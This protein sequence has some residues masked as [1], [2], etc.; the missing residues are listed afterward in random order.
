M[1]KKDVVYLGL[2]GGVDSAIAAVLLLEQGYDV[3]GVFLKI[4][5]D[6]LDEKNICPWVEERRDAINV[7]AKLGI[8]IE[9][10]DFE[11]AYK[12]DVFSYFVSEYSAG[13]T[14][15]PDI[16]CNQVI[17]FG[18]FLDYALKQGADYIATG[19]HVRRDPVSG[20]SNTVKLLA[21]IDQKKDQS[22]FLS[23]LNQFQLSHTL[24]P[25]GHMTKDQVREKA[26][27]LGLHNADKPSTKG[28]CFIGDVNLKEFLERYTI[29]QP[30]NIVNEAGAV[31]GKHEGVAFYTIGQRKGL[32]IPAVTAA[33]KPFFVTA[34]NA[35][36]NELVVSDRLEA[37]EGTRLFASR[38]H[39][40]DGKIKSFPLTCLAR[41]RYNQPLQEVTVQVEP[42]S[43]MEPL[44]RVDFKDP[45]RAIAPGQIIA[46][47]DGDAVLGNAVIT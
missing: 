2:S 11:E 21:G 5:S 23:S 32:H 45:Q 36:T 20:T 30:G 47:Y 28:I 24:F 15:N 38:L 42:S 10:I 27:E 25:I 14:P 17:K 6:E 7:A 26:R 31:I 41:I 18:A 16:L 44:L 4:W 22:Y 35:E 46:F 1:K 19:H 34:K 12:K 3:R 37:L 29:Q 13:R 40:I 43:R 9:T 39:W 33:S 8:P